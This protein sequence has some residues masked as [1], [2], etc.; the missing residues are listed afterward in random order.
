MPHSIFRQSL[1][2]A[3]AFTVTFE[4]VPGQGS[5]GKKLERILEFSRQAKEDGRI[6]ALSITDNPGGHPA[7][8][9][10]ALGVEIKK[11]G[12]EPLIHFSLKDKNRNQI[13]SHLFLYS[14]Q[15]ITSL[16]VLGGDFP[17]PNYYGQARPV[18]DLDVVQALQLMRDMEEG[19][20]RCH[21]RQR[22]AQFS[23]LF[24]YRGCVVSPFKTTEAEQVWQYAK[25]QRKIRAG[26]HFV[27]TQ[28]GF[29][30]DKQEELLR[31]MHM[32][33]LHVPVLGNVF[34]PTAT[35]ARSMAQGIVPGIFFPPELVEQIQQEEEKGDTE[36]KLQRAA[37]MI[38]VLRG[39]GYKGVHLGGNNLNFAAVRTILDL[40][41]ELRSDWQN[42]REELHYP[43]QNAWHLFRQNT[44]KPV[45][46]QPGQKKGFLSIHRACHQIFFSPNSRIAKLFGKICLKA[47]QRPSTNRLLFFFERCIKQLLFSC[48]MCG[49][50]TLPSSTYLCPQS[51]C[52]KNLVNGPCGGSRDGACEVH[53]ERSCFW[54][55]VYGRLETSTTLE[56][57]GSGELL[58]PKNWQLD[59][60]SSW[61]NHFR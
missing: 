61:V 54:V 58:P 21:T 17:R 15:Q 20:Y 4:L 51:G 23:P 47:A 19:S 53:P 24:F 31:F 11:I 44:A 9:P 16:L 29:D 2:S 60:T 33:A 50:C 52:P 30:M 40:A 1:T 5:G 41:D 25:L 12:I 28:L 35:V 26:A 13:E 42:F 8:A 59:Q 37:K 55:L 43:L 48:R 39:L 46:L 56:E 18:F 49:D 22:G 34:L 3:D 27:I 38:C 36:T 32:A 45:Q 57:L 7:L 10:V 6:R 14:R